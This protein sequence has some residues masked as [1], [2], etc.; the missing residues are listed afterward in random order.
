VQFALLVLS[1]AGY[2]GLPLVLILGWR[3]WLRRSS[4]QARLSVLSLIGFALSSSSALLALGTV[5]YA[6]AGG[7]F[8]YYDSTL[9]VIYRVGI[10][11][12]LGGLT[13]AIVGVWSRGAVRWH[14]LILSVG[15]LF[16]WLMCASA[17]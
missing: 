8:R 15:M 14:A 9:L 17:E 11:L 5:L 1:I 13:S 7:G 12:S 3:R 10:L 16:L 2:I 4:P 6:M